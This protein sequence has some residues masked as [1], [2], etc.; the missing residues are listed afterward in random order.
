MEFLIY[1]IDTECYFEKAEYIFEFEGQKF[2]LIRGTDKEYD[3]LCT[4]TQNTGRRPV[5]RG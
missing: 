5:E 3:K 2:R 1:Q 4:I